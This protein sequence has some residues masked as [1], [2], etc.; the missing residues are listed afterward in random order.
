[1]HIRRNVFL[2]LSL[3]LFAAMTGCGGGANIPEVSVTPPPPSPVKAM[4]MDVA[5]TGELGSGASMIREGLEAMKA[6]DPAK[7]SVLLE[8]LTVLEGLEDPAEIQAKAKSIA[9]EL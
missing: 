8:E 7:A 1:M 5:N 9:D 6:T 2:G 4:L 3:L